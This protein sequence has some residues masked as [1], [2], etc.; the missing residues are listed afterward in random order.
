[1]FGI[2]CCWIER[3]KLNRLATVSRIIDN[4]I[5]GILVGIANPMMFME[6]V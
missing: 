6:I 4:K 2:V 5:K 3:E 1:M